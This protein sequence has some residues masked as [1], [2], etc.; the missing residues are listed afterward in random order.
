MI[1]VLVSDGRKMDLPFFRMSIAA[2]WQCMKLSNLA[3]FVFGAKVMPI[4]E[5]L[6][7]RHSI[8]LGSVFRCFEKDRLKGRSFIQSR[9][10]GLLWVRLLPSGSFAPGIL[11]SGYWL[12]RLPT[13]EIRS[14][15]QVER[16]IVCH[17]KLW[18]HM[19]SN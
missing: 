11:Q 15:K 4:R 16:R 9:G 14:A 19:A 7:A 2:I 12:Q 1:L 6:K 17:S 5:G 18:R 13:P 10:V 8:H 3:F